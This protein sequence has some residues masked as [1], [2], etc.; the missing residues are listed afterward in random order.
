MHEQNFLFIICYFC[1]NFLFFLFFIYVYFL[2]LIFTSKAT[3]TSF[4]VVFTDVRLVVPSHCCSKVSWSPDRTF[5]N[6]HVQAT[7]SYKNHT[8]MIT[9]TG[10]L[11]LCNLDRERGGWSRMKVGL[12]RRRRK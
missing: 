9:N 6:L 10:V 8:L 7:H 2:F 11:Q 1:S 12:D 5:P 3:E 4:L